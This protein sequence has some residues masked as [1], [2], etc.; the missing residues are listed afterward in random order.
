MDDFNN[1]SKLADAF[2]EA[3]SQVVHKTAFDWLANAQAQIRTNHQIDTGFMVNSGYVRTYDESTYTQAS[4]PL[5]KGQEK[6][7]EVERPANNKEAFIGFGAA[8]TWWQNYGTS[9]IPARPFLEP[10]HDLTQ[11]SFDEALR[12]I[13]EKLKSI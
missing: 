1:W 3:Q 6:L 4:A 11:P 2:D 10:S 9:R 13:D 12:R 5:K 8:Y 7:P